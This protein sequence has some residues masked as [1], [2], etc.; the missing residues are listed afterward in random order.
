MFPAKSLSRQ[1]IATGIAVVFHLVGLVG[2]CWWDREEFIRLTPMNLLLSF[3][4]LMWCSWPDRIWWLA[5][6]IAWAGGYLSEVIGVNA[7][8]LFGDYIYGSAFG[9]QWLNV[10]LLM[11]VNWF[12]V[13]SG[14]QYIAER[15]LPVPVKNGR[16]GKWWI[17]LIGALLVFPFD[18]LV[19]PVA[20][21]LGYWTWLGSGEIPLYNYVCWV[22]ISFLLLVIIQRLPFRKQIWYPGA[23]LLIQ[24]V[25]FLLLNLY[26]ALN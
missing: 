1:R 12:L 15:L 5:A 3:A 26:F 11:G 16:V 2:I 22:L 20:I 4:L 25:F 23:L 13:L 18:F 7:G 17:A 21:K 14:V 8:W 9:F 19:E 10:P 6:A 24:A